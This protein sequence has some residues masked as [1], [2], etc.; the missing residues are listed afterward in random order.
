MKE[1]LIQY[2]IIVVKLKCAETN[3]LLHIF[4]CLEIAKLSGHSSIKAYNV[5]KYETFEKDTD[6]LRDRIDLYIPDRYNVRIE[7]GYTNEYIPNR[8]VRRGSYDDTRI[9]F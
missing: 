7:T 4:N 1:R 9:E 3:K 8:D 6:L 5:S 2:R